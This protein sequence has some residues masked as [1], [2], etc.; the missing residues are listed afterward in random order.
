MGVGFYGLIMAATLYDQILAGT[1]IK[2]G[3][4]HFLS[5]TIYFALGLFIIVP[6]YFDNVVDYKALFIRSVEALMLLAFAYGIIEGSWDLL[7]AL[8]NPSYVS[9]VMGAA[10][11]SGAAIVV[12]LITRLYALFNWK[13]FAIVL[14]VIF[15]YLGIWWLT[16]FHI[17]G[18][19]EDSN[20]LVVAMTEIGHWCIG[21]V[22][23]AWALDKKQMVFPSKTEALLA[24]GALASFVFCYWLLSGRLLWV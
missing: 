24:L 23:F 21:V 14:W 17:S 10:I 9:A 11:Y 7:F 1:V 22:G 2:I 3:G 13:R 4:N 12:A 8:T 19:P 5:E 18:Y 6:P 16:G 20:S 15:T